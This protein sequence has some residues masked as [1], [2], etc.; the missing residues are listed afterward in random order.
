MMKQNKR[1]QM[2]FNPPRVP[3]IRTNFMWGNKSMD[4]DG[5]KHSDHEDCRPFDRTRHSI[6]PSQTMKKRIEQ[7]PLYVSKKTPEFI[8]TGETEKYK[9]LSKEAKKYAPYEQRRV[10]SVIKK[11]PSIIGE[12]E[13]QQPSSVVYT[14]QPFHDLRVH[15]VTCP[16]KKEVVISRLELEYTPKKTQEAFVDYFYKDAPKIKQERA[17]E[18]VE[19]RPYFEEPKEVRAEKQRRY[20]AKGMFHELTH[21]KQAK[22][23]T[24]EEMREQSK[25]EVEYEERPIEKEAYTV[26]KQK[27]LEREEKGKEPSGKQITRTLELD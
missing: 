14:E 15:G 9:L 5:D 10:L 12:M 25:L 22:T 27:L 18:F 13:R 21:I 6:K 11:Y 26:A 17:K 4:I 16:E 19:E 2:M 23:M 24:P 3:V 8:L 7:L 20:V 1:N